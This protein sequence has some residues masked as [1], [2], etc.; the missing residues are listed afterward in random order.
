M[1]V[2]DGSGTEVRLPISVSLHPRNDQGPV[3][4]LGV[5]PVNVAIT[6][7]TAAGTWTQTFGAIDDD[8][9]P[10]HIIDYQLTGKCSYLMALHSKIT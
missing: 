10:H 6:E 1:V 7:D 3:Y 4:D 5:L 9:P 2:D 8:E